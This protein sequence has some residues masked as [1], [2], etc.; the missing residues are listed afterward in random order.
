[1]GFESMTGRNGC[2]GNKLGEKDRFLKARPLQRTFLESSPKEHHREDFRK[3]GE[4]VTE[5][6]YHQVLRTQKGL[7]RSEFSSWSPL[8]RRSEAKGKKGNV[9]FWFGPLVAFRSGVSLDSY[10]TIKV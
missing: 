7:G 4:G 1:M 6:R 2:S 9:T 8:R 10:H 3:R 5:L